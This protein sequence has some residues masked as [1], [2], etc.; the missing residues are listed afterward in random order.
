MTLFDPFSLL[1]SLILEIDTAQ[2]LESALATVVQIICQ[3]CQWLYGEAWQWDES[4]KVLKLQSTFYSAEVIENLDRSAAYPKQFGE[5]SASVRFPPSVGIPG[6]VWASQ[7]WEWH[8]DVSQVSVEVFKRAQTASDCGIKTAFGIPLISHQRTTAVLVFFSDTAMPENPAL[9]QAIEAVSHCI[10]RLIKQQQIEE[11]LEDSET[12]FQSFMAHSPATIF[13]KDQQGSYVYA[14]SQIKECCNPESEAF[15]AETGLLNKTDFHCFSNEVATRLQENDDLV[16]S[17]NQAQS[18]VEVIPAADGSKTYSQ[19]VKFPFTDRSGQKFIGGI[20][21][22]ITPLK[23]LEHQLTTDREKQEQ[24]NRALLKAMAAAEVA[25]EAKSSF[26]AMMSHEIRT[27]MNAIIGMI[28]LL[29]TTPL[30]SQ[31]Q[32]FVNTIRSGSNTLLTVINDILDFSKI[33]SRNLELEVGCIDLYDS[34][35][36]VLSLFASKAAD[37]GLTLTSLIEP[38]QNP[39]R[40]RGDATRLKQILSNLVSNSIKFTHQGEIS[41]QI[42]VSPARSPTQA[43]AQTNAQANETLSSHY[44]VQFSVKDTGIGISSEGMGQLF[45]PFSQTDTSMTRQYGG[46]GLGLSISKQLVEMMHGQIEVVSEVGKGS[47]FHFFVQLSADSSYPSRCETTF[48][49]ST[50]T[51]KRLLII[52]SNA[53]SRKSLVLQAQSWGLQVQAVASVEA[54]FS[55]LH[56]RSFDAIAISEPLSEYDGAHLIGQIRKLPSY[57]TLPCILLQSCQEVL[58]NDYIRLKEQLQILHQPVRRSQFYNAL[59]QLLQPRKSENPNQTCSGPSEEATL[60]IKKPLR[61]LL[62]EDIL[63]NQKV[64]LQ[65]LL[66]YGYQADVAN[67]GQEAIQALRQQSYNLVFMDVQMPKMDGLEATREIRRNLTIEQPYIVAMTAH[68][69]QSDREDCLKAG[70]DD[71]VS[72]PIRRKDLAAALHRCPVHKVDYALSNSAH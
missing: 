1:Q 14:N 63:L 47:T 18:F 45:K 3:H 64:A 37:K 27:P 62:T 25:T 57:Q 35:D 7:K 67:N 34:V 22:N 29:S 31:Q 20:A 50:L 8:A 4:A 36:Q 42:K 15:Q 12:R 10:S 32:D 2:N 52:D 17:T 9:I 56:H 60:G 39:T 72:K 23:Q 19:V 58:S 51:E 68:S 44:K 65:M 43:N 33:E 55:Q 30:S 48:I 24:L 11:K 53:T 46:T 54:M 69:M 28:D 66:S 13:M 71:Y 41:I 21:V 6:R 5:L 26:L 49:A 16:L 38:A 61:I 70:M 59:V 40:F